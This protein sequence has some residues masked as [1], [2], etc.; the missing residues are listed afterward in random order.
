MKLHIVGC[1]SPYPPYNGAGPGYLLEHKGV[2]VLLDCG[3]GVVSH[4]RRV[5]D[6]REGELDAVVLS[7]LHSDHFCDLLVLR[8]AHFKTMQEGKAGPLLVHA[9]NSPTLERELLP[10]RDVLNI[11][12]VD[13]ETKIAFGEMNVSFYQTNHSIPCYAMRIEAGGRSLVYT[14]DTT[15]DD[16]LVRFAAKADVLLAECTFLEKDKGLNVPKH[17][18]ALDC[19]RLAQEA[20]VKK[21]VLTHLWPEY[22]PE[23]LEQEAK[24]K[25]YGS[26]VVASM[27]LSQEV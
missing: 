2:K 10:F 24:S 15:W 9:P 12:P 20:R 7:H 25:F 4:L 27:G 14:A 22:D 23:L 19:G 16:E 13:K 21:L 11:Q 8:Y 6:F 18:S 26:I 3:S 5:C 1:Y 17:L